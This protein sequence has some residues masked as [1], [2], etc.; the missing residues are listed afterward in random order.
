MIQGLSSELRRLAPP[1]QLHHLTGQVLARLFSSCPSQECGSPYARERSCRPIA[2][3]LDHHGIKPAP[4]KAV[5]ME[6]PP[7]KPTGTGAVRSPK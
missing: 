3:I 7:D 5:C 1:N 2:R 4:R 6:R